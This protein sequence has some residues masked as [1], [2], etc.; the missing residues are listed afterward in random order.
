MQFC[1]ILEVGVGERPKRDVRQTPDTMPALEHL[2][3]LASLNP[4]AH[5]M[6]S[7]RRNDGVERSREQW[8]RHANSEHPERGGAPKSRTFH[9]REWME[10]SRHRQPRTPPRSSFF[11]TVVRLSLAANGDRRSI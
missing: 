10:Q 3:P 7:E 2:R 8:F 5:L 6:I 4:H 9:G 11:E 1:V